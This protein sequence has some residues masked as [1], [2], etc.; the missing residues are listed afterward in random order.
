ML[1][2]SRKKE[3]DLVKQ[4]FENSKPKSELEGQNT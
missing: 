1:E 4:A 2:I 3:Y